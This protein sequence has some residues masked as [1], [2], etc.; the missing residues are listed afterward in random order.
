MC[1]VKH[2]LFMNFSHSKPQHKKYIC[3]RESFFQKAVVPFSLIREISTTPFHNSAQVG[4]KISFL[5]EYIGQKL[6]SIELKLNSSI[7]NKVIF[8]FY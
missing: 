8:T 6:I 2:P 7:F 5:K 1:D 4:L 3:I